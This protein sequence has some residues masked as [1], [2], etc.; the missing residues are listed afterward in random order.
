MSTEVLRENSLPNDEG[1]PQP[2]RRVCSRGVW[3]LL[4]LPVTWF[5]TRAALQS[6]RGLDLTDEGLYLLEAN[7]AADGV[8]L[9]TPYGW[10]TQVLWGLAGADVARFRTVG[11]VILLLLAAG[12]A[13]TAARAGAAA[14]RSPQ[15]PLVNGR[16]SDA[17]VMAAGALSGLLFYAGYLRTP[18]Y[19]WAN[20]VGLIVSLIGLLR[21]V[22]RSSITPS[23]P[24]SST[25]RSTLSLPDSVLVALGAFIAI[26]AKPT[27]PVL[28][29]I[30]A[31]PLLARIGGHAAAAWSLMRVALIGCGIIAAAV[32]GRIWPVTFVQDFMS[33]ASAP[34]FVSSQSVVGATV[35]LLRIPDTALRLSPAILFSIVAVAWRSV[36]RDRLRPRVAAGAA[37]IVI[38]ISFVLSRLLT[39]L[40]SLLHSGWPTDFVADLVLQGRAVEPVLHYVLQGQR[41]LVA[42]TTALLVLIGYLGVPAGASRRS[43]FGPSATALLGIPFA[44]N[45]PESVIAAG[46][47]VARSADPG[48]TTTLVL[49]AV[50]ISVMPTEASARQSSQQRSV[51]RTTLALLWALPFLFGFGTSNHLYPQAGMAAALFLALILFTLAQRTEQ[52]SWTSAVAVTTAVIAAV[53]LVVGFDSIAK[54]YRTEN[55]RSSS[56][57]LLVGADRELLLLGRSSAESLGT[58]QAAALAEGWVHGTLLL[59]TSHRWAPG[60][61]WALGAQPPPSAVLTIGGY[62]E[63]T[64]LRL[65]HSLGRLGTSARPDAW[66]LVTVAPDGS[67]H[68]Y[69]GPITTRTTMWISTVFPDDYRRVWRDP[70]ATNHALELWRPARP[71]DR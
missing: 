6:D 39:P 55:I 67:L 40:I 21:H 16:G 1:G 8:F 64:M 24:A 46:D 63:S 31:Y 49:I 13:R 42:A 9:T 3:F 36:P 48:L 56:V 28:I 20:L 69:S 2:P 30:I 66:L 57:P 19:N 47:G 68:E 35:A 45:L 4:G 60:V 51:A 32:L 12:L 65:E 11:G 44:L 26:P 41:L 34:A 15:T 62:G 23:F 17:L 18:G 29:A 33:A 5:L 52:S 54:P 71:D 10:H 7:S 43:R 61:L 58:L 53:T 70:T 27:T 50:A 37:L 25:L 14:A 22:E 59:D 38:V